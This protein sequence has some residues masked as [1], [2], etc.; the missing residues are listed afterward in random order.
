MFGPGWGV[1]WLEIN[2]QYPTL[3]VLH[4]CI[5]LAEGGAGRGGAKDRKQDREEIERDIK[6]V[7]DSSLRAYSMRN[8]DIPLFPFRHFKICETLFVKA[9]SHLYHSPLIFCLD[10]DVSLL[11]FLYYFITSMFYS[12]MCFRSFLGPIFYLCWM[13]KIK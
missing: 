10:I 12:N 7:W 3:R 2:I 6:G 5:S 4:V 13:K 1:W 8:H 9:F 11:L